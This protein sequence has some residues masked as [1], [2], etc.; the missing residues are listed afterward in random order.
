MSDVPCRLCGAEQWVK[1][2][3][4]TF[5]VWKEN[6]NELLRDSKEYPLGECQ[7]CG[8]VQITFDYTAELF[9]TLYFHSAQEAVMWH[10]ELV[11][12]DY[13]YQ[14]MVEFASS[15]KEPM[16]VV[17]FGCGEG[18]LLSVVNTTYKNSKLI[19]IDFND[20][21]FLKNADYVSHN[22]N[23]LSDLPRNFWPNG[24]DLATASHVLEHMV[25]P[26]DFLT[27]I[28]SHLSQGGTIFIEVPDFTY[29]HDS[30]LIGKSNLVNLQHIHYFTADSLTYIAGQAGLV[31]IKLQ[32]ITT[33]YIPRLQALFKRAVGQKGRQTK[34]AK[35]HGMNVVRHYQAICL[36][37]RKAFAYQLTEQ[38]QRDKVIGLWG[39]G[40]DFYELLNESPA[41][42]QAIKTNSLVLF[43]YGH[44]GK[45]FLS[46]TI[47]SSSDIPK[48]K[49]KVFVCPVL[50]ETTIKMREVSRH[51]LNVAEFNDSELF[52]GG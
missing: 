21:F 15:D 10:E 50:I 52:H 3:S 13:P 41:L 1:F 36:Q 42:I 47:L 9:S 45:Q 29:P 49:F 7:Q 40:A 37:R 35:F 32:H 23:D 6:N 5:G 20:R 34:Y 4:I 26:V 39:L 19:G 44:K 31:V 18:R 25:D 38:I 2:S 8:H 43:D 17:D 48:Q 33:G 22:L 51:W 30:N 11:D 24:I 28:K 12:S 16:V 14:N 27:H 46:Q